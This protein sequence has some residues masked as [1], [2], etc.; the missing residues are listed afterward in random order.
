MRDSRSAA[1]RQKVF[2]EVA[3]MVEVVSL[4]TKRIRD[5]QANYEEERRSVQIKH[6]R[7]LA[8]LHTQHQE[9]LA[10]LEIKA[11]I[12][13]LKSRANDMAY[14]DYYKEVTTASIKIMNNSKLANPMEQAAAFCRQALDV[15]EDTLE[16]LTEFLKCLFKGIGN[17]HIVGSLLRKMIMD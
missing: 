12:Q 16:Q 6:A 5:N 1:E 10:A 15:D 17:D 2:D 13:A 11:T 14:C 9:E 4:L 3:A 8:E 7:Q